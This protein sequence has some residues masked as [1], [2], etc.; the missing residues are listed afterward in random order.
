ML[1]SVFS[2]TIR[3]IYFKFCRCTARVR[4]GS[5]VALSYAKCL[6]QTVS[7]AHTFTQAL[8]NVSNAF[9]S[10]VHSHARS[11]ESKSVFY[12]TYLPNPRAVTMLASSKNVQCQSNN[13]NHGIDLWPHDDVSHSLKMSRSCIFIVP[14]K[15]RS[16]NINL[17][18]W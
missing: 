4:K 11:I 7:F 1:S 16:L 5:S 10:N 14:G 9:L 15:L 6:L 8:S 17:D 12:P 18:L 3:L 13:T 2:R